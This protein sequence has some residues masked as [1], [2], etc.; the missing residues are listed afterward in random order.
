MKSHRLVERYIFKTILVYSL[1]ALVLLTSILFAQQTARYFETIFHGVMPSGFVYGLAIALLPTVVLFTLPMSILCGVIIGLGRISSDSELVAMRAAGISTWRTLWPAL[2]VGLVA[3]IG[4]AY[5]NLQEA[6]RAQRQLRSVALRSA[7]Y[8]LDSPVEPRTFTNDFPGYVIYVRDGDKAKGQWGRVFI[9]TQEPDHATN[10]ITARAG[11]I[12]SS[13]ETSELVLQDAMKTRV[14]APDA[15]DQ[16]YVVERLSQLRILFNTGRAALLAKLEKP[17]PDPEQMGIG[18]LKRY[19]DQTSGLEQR[20]A[21]ITLHKRLAFSI[22]P[23]VFSL[24]G[25]TLAFRMRRGS[26]GFG[27][28]VSLGI[29]VVYYLLTVGGDQAARAGTV[30]PVLGAWFS[31]GVVL[32]LGV[33]L[34]ISSRRGSR[35]QFMGARSLAQ[36]AS[37]SQ[38]SKSAF[39]ARV[40]PRLVLASF[41]TLL[42]VSVIRTMLLSFVIAFIALVIIFDVF[43]TFEL[44]RFISTNRASVRLVAEYLFYLLPLVSIEL[45]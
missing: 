4:S 9:Q 19:A 45:F 8:K 15:R 35:A 44:W 7:L 25:A 20:D 11:R 24:F 29:L 26:R 36:G 27:M 14:P 31:T 34:L 10:L 17:E 41:P 21:K 16:S 13:A 1:I 39:R 3:S 37:D 42:D 30:P 28:L 32:A 43:T 38:R 2:V 22:A 18:A 5:L 33:L 40:K 23:F 12:D 6:P